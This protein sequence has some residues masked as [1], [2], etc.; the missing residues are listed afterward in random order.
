MADSNSLGLDFEKETATEETATDQA[1]NTPEQETK[2]EKK[3]PYVNPERVKTGGPQRVRLVLLVLAHTTDAWTKEKPSEEE[4]AERMQRIKEQNEK[5]KQR[6]LDV[7]ADEDAF[8]KMQETERVK[9]AQTRKVQ[10]G[11]D[12]TREQNARRKMEKMQSREWDS[13][14]PA[15]EWK[16]AKEGE[17]EQRGG[18]PAR[19]GALRGPRGR[20]R[21][22]SGRG[23]APV[24]EARDSE[25][26]PTAT[27]P[28]TTTTTTARETE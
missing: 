16:Q 28:T 10:E 18:K 8:K 5:I 27:P 7:K 1:A 19:G 23:A 14:K 2:S 4:L 25:P 11:V 26:A 12:R 17:T 22:R 6:R 9:Q 15:G 21:G 20:G 13:G 24:S 3:K